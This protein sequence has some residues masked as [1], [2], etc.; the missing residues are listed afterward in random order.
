MDNSSEPSPLHRIVR[1]HDPNLSSYSPV[2]L[3]RLADARRTLKKVDINS[4]DKAGLT[5][6]MLCIATLP[7]VRFGNYASYDSHELTLNVFRDE[8]IRT[9]HEAEFKRLDACVQAGVRT[10]V[11]QQQNDESAR[12]ILPKHMA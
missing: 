2:K 7:P 4:K 1:D 6:Y 12:N 3:E 9:R 8:D 11:S 10:L 5:P